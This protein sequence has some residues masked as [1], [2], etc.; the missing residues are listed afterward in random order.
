MQSPKV[1]SPFYAVVNYNHAIFTVT[2]SDDN[3]CY[4]INISLCCSILSVS[5]THTLYT[6]ERETLVSRKLGELSAIYQT[7]TIKVVV[8]INSRLAAD[9]FAKLFST[10]HLK[11]SNSPSNLPAIQYINPD[12]QEQIV[13][14]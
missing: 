14:A 6:V 9:L 7:K 11:K 4:V 1:A 12:K 2:N 5:S 3:T 10:K 13:C 8:S